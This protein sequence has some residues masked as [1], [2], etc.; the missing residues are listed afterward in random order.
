MEPAEVA[1]PS[2]D[3]TFIVDRCPRQIVT[4]QTIDAMS[5]ISDADAGYLPVAGGM[6]D[7][8]QGFVDALRYIRR[9]DAEQ[10]LAKE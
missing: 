5:A 8:S 4:A 9:I 1:D 3:G 10:K 6:L 2:G 7:Q